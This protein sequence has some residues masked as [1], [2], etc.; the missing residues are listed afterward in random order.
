MNFCIGMN[1]CNH[2][3]IQHKRITQSVEGSKSR[4]R[5]FQKKFAVR[6]RPGNLPELPDCCAE[7]T[8]KTAA[9]LPSPSASLLPGPMA[10]GLASPHNHVSQF[11]KVSYFPEYILSHMYVFMYLCYYICI[12]IYMIE[13][14]HK[15]YICIYPVC[16]LENP[17]MSASL[18]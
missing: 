9:S 6:L 1:L 17:G 7:L 8:L 18:F 13:Y 2:Y 10:F 16:F 5:G 14:I 4:D 11:L 3:P 15:C 12:L